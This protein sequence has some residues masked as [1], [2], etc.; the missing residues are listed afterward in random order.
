[1]KWMAWTLLGG[2]VIVLLAAI[3]ALWED[4]EYLS[5]S[6][7][8]EHGLYGKEPHHDSDDP[9]RLQ[10]LRKIARAQEG[11]DILGPER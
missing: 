7:R 4:Q 3:R 9:S 10:L 8:R 5:A 11:K 6:W 2:V 1:M